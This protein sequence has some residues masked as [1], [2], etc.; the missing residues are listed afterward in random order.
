MRAKTETMK[1][2]KTM[3]T[4]KTMQGRGVLKMRTTKLGIF[5][6][7]VLCRGVT[8]GPSRP[9]LDKLMLMFAAWL[10]SCHVNVDALP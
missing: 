1:T 4:Q 6:V 2:M 10:C 7:S 3:T 9:I 5:L 8:L